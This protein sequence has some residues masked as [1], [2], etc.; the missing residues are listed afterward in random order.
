MSGRPIHNAPQPPSRATSS[1]GSTH[2]SADAALTGAALA[3][4]KPKPPPKPNL[5]GI[6][7]KNGAL[8]AANSSWEAT[9]PTPVI[10][11]DHQI[12]QKTRPPILPKRT[13]SPTPPAPKSKIRDEPTPRFQ[14]LPP[15]L[16]ARPASIAVDDASFEPRR[17]SNIP[18][19]PPPRRSIQ[20]TKQNES[21]FA[22]SA[23]ILVTRSP[24]PSILPPPTIKGSNQYKGKSA[25]MIESYFTDTTLADAIVGANL[26]ISRNPSPSPPRLRELPN[27]RKQLRSPTKRDSRSN[28]PKKRDTGLRETLRPEHKPSSDEARGRTGL[29][30]R[31]HPHKH[32]EGE[33]KRWREQVTEDEY[34]RYAGLW[35]T[36]KGLLFSQRER[37]STE[38]NIDDEICSVVAREL[39]RRS[40]LPDPIL[41][42]IWDLVNE[43]KV[44]R[45]TKAQF[46]VGLW[47]I[48]QRLMGRKVPAKVVPSVWQSVERFSGPG[49]KIRLI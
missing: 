3:F 31:R 22:S 10:S 33:R 44:A 23:A 40:R 13:S 9:R 11:T 20:P 48:D 1:T 36:N 14:S 43:R 32:H 8:I 49:V 6:T 45:L 27:H 29:G 17:N 38:D 37:N 16:P 15:S 47:L 24:K 39:W 18:L 34:K 25:Q 26:A 35:A 41:Y 12:D 19:P 30:V 42:Q 46:I 7:T 28:S 5:A 4:G 2:T 21:G